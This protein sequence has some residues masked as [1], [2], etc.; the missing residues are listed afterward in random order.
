MTQSKP[1]GNIVEGKTVSDSKT[2]RVVSSTGQVLSSTC[3][4]TAVS[5]TSEER[6]YTPGPVLSTFDTPKLDNDSFELIKKSGNIKM[7]DY[8]K[9]WIEITDSLATIPRDVHAFSMTGDVSNNGTWG[10]L[11]AEQLV[12]A[13]AQTSYSIKGDLSELK[14]R[15]PNITHHSIDLDGKIGK[16]VENVKASVVTSLS[17][18]YDLL[19]EIAE[20]KDTLET[21]RSILEAILRP[22]KALLNELEK[23]KKSK[24][25]EAAILKRSADLWL[26]WRYAIMPMYYSLKDVLNTIVQ[27][28][29][30]YR[31]ERSKETLTGEYPDVPK[32]E[33]CFYDH[34]YG[35]AVIRAVGKEKYDLGGELHLMELIKFNPFST[36]YELI[37][38]SFV[39]DWFV[40]VGDWIS[41]H[42]SALVTLALERKFCYSIKQSL[43]VETFYRDYLQLEH[44]DGPYQIYWHEKPG[45]L[46]WDVPKISFKE[47]RSVDY[48]L[49]REKRYLYQRHTFSPDDVQLRFLPEMTTKRWIDAFALALGSTQAK[50]K[51]L[52]R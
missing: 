37:P 5:P 22:R 29:L 12:R 1:Y 18:T 33:Q 31:T 14:R 39:F 11:Y 51:A 48:L 3:T 49:R 20:L 17:N 7:T 2:T 46:L 32:D 38:G 28:R 27:S 15:F 21:V 24:L 4:A 10:Q 30:V 26:Q 35:T 47:N 36:A 23:L 6:W 44:S 9:G 8:I 42:T 25:P 41:A 40:N 19:T 16:L 52:R 34:M 13:H 50:L 45:Y 43:Y